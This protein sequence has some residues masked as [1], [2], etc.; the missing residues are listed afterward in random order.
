MKHVTL[1]LHGIR[2][3]DAKRDVIRFIEKYWG[4]GY[5]AE[6]ITGNSHIMRSIVTDILDEYKLTYNIGRM[7]ELSKSRVITWLE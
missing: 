1:D 6:I 3:E 5:E 7:F 2:H 4:T